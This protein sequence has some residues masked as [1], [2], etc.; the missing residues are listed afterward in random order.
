MKIEM[1]IAIEA[2]PETIWGILSDF[3][4]YPEWNP[5]LKEV[6]GAVALEAEIELDL[7]YN[8]PKGRPEG[9][10]ATERARVTAFSAPR[11]FSWVWTHS[12]G[13]W[14]LSAERIFRIKARQDGKCTFF[15]EAYYSGLSVVKLLGFLDFNREK[16]E[17]RLK[18]PMIKMNDALKARAEAAQAARP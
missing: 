4:A 7:L 10:S 8:H 13:D 2:T 1:D 5:Y 18:L 9:Q 3:A 16:V 6:R 12:R 14:W 11:Y 17:H 15:N